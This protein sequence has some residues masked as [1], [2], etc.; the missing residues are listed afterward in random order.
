MYRIIQIIFTLITLI[1]IHFYVETIMNPTDLT[2]KSNDFPFYFLCGFAVLSNIGII[3]YHATTPPHPKFLMTN[4]RK[5]WVRIHAISGSIELILGIIAWS[6]SYEFLA[7]IVGFTALLFHVPSSFFQSRGAFGA[8]GITVPSYY[9]IVTI[10]AYFAFR[11]ITS[12][13]QIYWLEQTWIA[14][15]AYAYMRIFMVLLENLKV[16]KGSHYTVT[17]LFA[18]A[19]ITSYL[20]GGFGTI[21]IVIGVLIYLGMFKLLMK[22]SKEEME[23]LF[24]EKERESL[25]D[26]DTRNFWISNN[27]EINVNKGHN[28]LAKEIFSKLDKDNSGYLSYDEIVQISKEWGLKEKYVEAIFKR[29]ENSKGLTLHDFKNTL[30]RMGNYKTLKENEIQSNSPEEK[31]MTIFKHLDI[32]SS[33]YLELSEIELLLMEWGLEPREAQGYITKYAGSDKKIDYNEF[34]MQMKPIWSFG[35]KHFYS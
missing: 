23:N 33:G 4:I 21:L 28:D 5:I 20:F 13:G 1:I 30:W 15:Q 24:E 26:N 2:I 34:F 18:G 25:I 27:L 16:F 32:D 6:M 8:K 19:V 31:A 11:L 14:L 9:M 22:P 12:G 29:F 10:H 7:L 3:Y 17:E 35:F